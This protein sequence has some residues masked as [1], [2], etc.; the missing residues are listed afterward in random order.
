MA[1]H[2]KLEEVRLNPLSTDEG[3]YILTEWLV[4]QGDE[5][6]MNQVIA[7]VE[8]NTFRMDIVSHVPG[9]VSEMNCIAGQPVQP[10]QLIAKIN[11]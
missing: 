3:E 7:R 11:P 1:G 9:K 2:F 10:Y 6:E 4:E 8:T 5:V